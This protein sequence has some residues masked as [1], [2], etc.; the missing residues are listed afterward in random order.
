ML[1]MFPIDNSA[2]PEELNRSIKAIREALRE[3]EDR[4]HQL[5]KVLPAAIYT[6]DA[7]GYITFYNEAAAQ[8]WGRRPEIG[9][10]RW[11]GSWKM[12]D[13]D[14]RPMPLDE[15]PMAVTLK[16]QTAVTGT[17]I[18]V[19]KPDGTRRFIQPYPQPAFNAEG[20]F[21]GAT[22][23]LIDVTDAKIAEEQSAYLAAIINSSDDAIISKTLTGMITSWNRGAERI[24]GYAAAEMIGQN[25][26]R[27]IPPERSDEETHI[28]AQ[29]KTGRRIDH[30]ET[31][32][33]TKT[34]H[35][36]D[37][38]VTISPIFNKEGKIIGASKIARDITLEKQAEKIVRERDDEFKALLES[39]LRERTQELVL[40]N[41]QLEKSNHDLEQFA[42][43]ASHDLQE[44]LR[45]ILTFSELVSDNA[46]GMPPEQLRYL[47]KIRSSARQMTSLIKDVLN[48]SRLTATG[49]R[50]ERVDLDLLFREVLAEFDLL[51]EQLGATIHQQ[52]L[53]VT[54]GIPVQLKQL[55]R[56]LLSNALKFCDGPPV[57]H[58][59]AH[60]E[61]GVAT[62]VFKDNGIGFEQVYADKIFHIF[63]RL[64]ARDK[65]NGT[66]VGLALCKKI[67]ENHNGSIRA[68]S[69]PGQ[70]TTFY[71]QLPA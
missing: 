60:T 6:C 61:N 11:C 44:P 47:G 15:C 68:E 38:S 21:S 57:V 62:L 65:Y 69:A 36:I 2:A 56:N 32:R 10:D 34:G 33:L 52:P 5:L 45:K 14:G 26:S 42:Y 8:L 28:I 16:T 54:N 46:A 51:C 67:A 55:F 71:I 3:S 53:P 9:T 70:G 63:N 27:I 30:F 58:V 64:H 18:I 29:L 49:E 66:G 20:N 39:I 23:L 19:E 41:Q 7:A 1:D 35:L 59:H 4:F 50:H 22:N 25:I 31:Q 12:F 24:F 40:L 43:I 13:T 37:I 17:E 48:Y